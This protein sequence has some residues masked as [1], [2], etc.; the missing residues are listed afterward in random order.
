[1]K[2]VYRQVATSLILLGS[3]WICSSCLCSGAVPPTEEIGDSVSIE[4]EVP[5]IYPL[6]DTSYASASVVDYRVDVFD[7]ITHPNIEESNPE[8][9]D[10]YEKVSG[11]LTFRGN[12]YRSANYCL[13]VEGEPSSIN[14]DWT[15]QTDFDTRKTSVGTWGGGSGWTG[16]PLYIQWPDSLLRKFRALGVVKDSTLREEVMFGSLASRIYFID[17]RTGKA[18]RPSIYVKN[19][20]KGTIVLDPE[21]NGLLYVGQGVPAE[22][23]FGSLVIDLFQ[24]KIVQTFPEDGNAYRRWQAYDSSPIRTGKFLFRPG[25]NNTLY[26]YVVE[27]GGLKLYST[28]RYKVGGAAPGMEASMAVYKNYGYTA[29]NNG[30]LL[31]VNLNTLKPVWH[32]AMGDDTDATP[33]VTIENDTAYVYTGCEIDKQGKGNAKFVKLN[34]VSGEPAWVHNTAGSRADIGSKHFDGGY[35]AS[36]LL[37]QGDCDSLI[38]AHCVLNTSGQ[39]GNLIAFNRYTG[40]VKYRVPFKRYAWSSPIAIVDKANKM[41]VL[42]ADTQGKVFII[43]GEDG[44]VL[45]SKQVGTNFE[46]TP[47]PVS[48]GVV[49]GSRGD[50]FYKISI[51]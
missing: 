30:N 13:N 35:Y 27:E 33:I 37:G 23:P 10:P 41:Y 12:H 4:V 43:R 17:P 21:L 6:P 2:I 8:F 31:C 20:I 45:C 49:I 3:L 51:R 42:Q 9:I 25:E 40:Q 19:P 38:F 48:D 14:I 29:D 50:S 22:R 18:S 1:M 15:F 32:Y 28:L 46:S 16:Q 47:I 34:A 36:P 24:H 11:I 26:K 39:D 44:K 5:K 7:S